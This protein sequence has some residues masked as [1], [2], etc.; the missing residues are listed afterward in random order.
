M[1]AGDKLQ[2]KF[3]G[4]RGSIPT[5]ES[6]AM[7][8]GG[9]TSCVE[10][11]Y[12]SQPPVIFDAGS[13]VRRL[14]QHWL[15]SPEE[16]PS[17]VHLLFTHFHW[18]HIQGLPFFAPLYNRSSEVQLS[19]CLDT[20]QLRLILENQMRT[21]YF[22]LELG[23]VQA[24]TEFC[25]LEPQGYELGDLVI[26]PFP[27]RHPGGSTGFRI[28]A[29]TACIVYATDH[30]HGD[31]S[32]DG[33]LRKHA[34]DADILIYDAQYTPEEYTRRRGWG[35]STWEAGVR[36]AR[37]AD[38]KQLVLFH[39]DPDHDDR[40]LDDLVGRAGAQFERT[41]AAREGAVFAV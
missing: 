38:V 15:N 12:G 8:Y 37:A 10:V 31:E 2:V 9:N 27:L 28:Q 40:A 19:S 39:H 26:T 13:G 29:P 16:F 11:R 36:T 4:V 30:E 23:A 35:H 33:I 41:A 7:R 24:R 32:F 34:R 5:A 14:G 20:G 18:D 3:W 6:G 25:Q 21:P 1:T 22:P 17:Q